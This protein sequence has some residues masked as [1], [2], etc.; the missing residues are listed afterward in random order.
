MEE[1]EGTLGIESGRY[2]RAWNSVVVG[3][4]ERERKRRREANGLLLAFLDILGQPL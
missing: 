1:H 3:R 4:Q 2:L